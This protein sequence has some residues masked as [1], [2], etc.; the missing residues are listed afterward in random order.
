MSR[1]DL[2][3]TWVLHHRPYRNTS[4]I[5][6]LITPDYGRV[7]VVANGIRSATSRRRPLLQPFRPLLTSWTGRS[8]L[9]TLTTVEESGLPVALE[10]ARLACG[11]YITELLLKLLRD[12]ESDVEIFALYSRVLSELVDHPSY[13]TLL[14]QFEVSLLTLLGVMPGWATTRATTRAGDLVDASQRYWLSPVTGFLQQ[15]VSDATP[16]ES[17]MIEASGDVLLALGSGDIHARHLAEAKRI[18]R[19]LVHQQLGGQT[20]NSRAMFSLYR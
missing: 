1:V 18:M 8:S 14:R 17:G 12:G 3:A 10:G 4:I 11:Y 20:L 19:S 16:Q 7:S 13:E 6:D 9:K 15:P 2:Q 5:A